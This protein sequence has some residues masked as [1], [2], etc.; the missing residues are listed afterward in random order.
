[1]GKLR[2]QERK[3]EQ[4]RREER[5]RLDD[6]EDT[7]ASTS[8]ATGPSLLELAG[9]EW[10]QA[11]GDSWASSQHWAEAADALVEA[12]PHAFREHAYAV[13]EPLQQAEEHM[14][15]ARAHELG[16]TAEQQPSVDAARV[17]Y[18]STLQVAL[19]SLR[20][21]WNQ[22]IEGTRLGAGWQLPELSRP[23]GA[24]P[25]VAQK[26]T[27]GMD[28]VATAARMR[29]RA[30]AVP[31]ERPS[32]DGLALQRPWE[33]NAAREAL[34]PVFD[35]FISF[36]G[37]EWLFLFDQAKEGG[38]PD[39]AI[40]ELTREVAG[41]AQYEAHLQDEGKLEVLDAKI[42]RL[43]QALH[44]AMKHWGTDEAA[45]TMAEIRN[46]TRPE[47]Q[48]LRVQYALRY[49]TELLGEIAGEL[50][51]ED[52]SEVVRSMTGDP[53]W[54]ALEA[55]EN[56]MDDDAC[57]PEQI[58]GVLREIPASE[59]ARFQERLQSD[60]A[61]RKLRDRILSAYHVRGTLRNKRYRDREWIE[62]WM[63]GEV[64]QAE[65]LTLELRATDRSFEDPDDGWSSTTLAGERVID[66]DLGRVI[67]ELEKSRD[68][69][70]LERAFDERHGYS[71]RTWITVSGKEEQRRL[72]LALLDQHTADSEEERQAAQ[73]QETV[74]RVKMGDGQGMRKALYDEDLESDDEMLRASALARRERVKS[75][76]AD[77]YGEEGET[78]ED[79]LRNY[80]VRRYTWE[81]DERQALYVYEHGRESLA[82]GAWLAMT[83][84][85]T[86]EDWLKELFRGRSK[87]EMERAA[88]EY[89]EEFG[90]DLH[91]D[92]DSEL[93]WDGTTDDTEFDI[94]MHARGLPETAEEIQAY[95]QEIHA[96]HRGG[97]WRQDLL[98]WAE[99][100]FFDGRSGAELDHHHQL[101]MDLFEEGGLRPGVDLERAKRLYRWQLTATESYTAAKAMVVEAIKVGAEI[102]AAAVVTVLT[103]GAASPWLIAAI[104]G[105]AYTA[106]G[107]VLGGSSASVGT[108]ATDALV[109]AASAALARLVQVKI[110]VDTAET[111]HRMR[112]LA[113]L[114][115]DAAEFGGKAYKD[116]VLRETI[117]LMVE[118]GGVGAVEAA[119]SEETWA[120]GLDSAFL[121][122]LGSALRDAGV[123]IFSEAMGGKLAP[124]QLQ[125]GVGQF[126]VQTGTTWVVQQP[127]DA[128]G[129][130]FVVHSVMRAGSTAISWA[131]QPL[132]QE[133]ARERAQRASTQASALTSE[134]RQAAMDEMKRAAE[135]AMGSREM[136]EATR[137][138][139]RA[140]VEQYDPRDLA[141]DALSGNVRSHVLPDL[142]GAPP[143]PAVPWPLRHTGEVVTWR[144]QEWLVGLNMSDYF[145]LIDPASGTMV[146]ASNEELLGD[147][148]NH[149][150][151][152][153]LPEKTVS[154]SASPMDASEANHLYR[155]SLADDATREVAVFR[156]SETRDYIVL[157]GDQTKATVDGKHRPLSAGYPQQWKEILD[158]DVGQWLLVVHFHPVHRP[159]DPTLSRVM[160]FPS[161]VGGDLEVLR[162]TGAQQGPV[163]RSWIDTV[164][165][166][167]HTRTEFGYDPTTGR[168]YVLWEE[169]QG[170]LQRREFDSIEAYEQFIQTELRAP[171]PAPS[172]G[173]SVRAI[174]VEEALVW[175]QHGA[176]KIVAYPASEV[177]GALVVGGDVQV[178]TEN[179]R[180]PGTIV[181]ID[182]APHSWDVDHPPDGPGP[183]PTYDFDTPVADQLEGTGQLADLRRNP[184]LKG[185]DLEALL[186]RTPRQLREMAR[187]GEISQET[188]RQIFKAF[189]GRDL[190]PSARGRR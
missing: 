47:I 169:Q 133:P 30:A 43:A 29:E 32:G 178:P 58:V 141:F 103:D 90:R 96:H 77:A 5:P 115:D 186:L 1:M 59:R 128:E 69:A 24:F 134:Q 82:I 8:T 20:G 119:L 83:D 110:L 123:S 60:P 71:L 149:H 31:R 111:A 188:R 44:E 75:T 151:L 129:V 38:L 127:S 139:L 175:V 160:R 28:L 34:G 13:A 125:T 49:D 185:V 15:E 108:V 124:E 63:D 97:G 70:A 183:L 56:R 50:S 57:D 166:W 153:Q 164:A 137:E 37:H 42:D 72:A 27:Q 163:M 177:R 132:P 12:D 170:V 113:V 114:A 146:R 142:P 165:P 145:T 184:N 80:L 152:D 89:R 140:W 45:M 53:V 118:E 136:S 19:A 9:R 189:E 78:S 91:D 102:I 74:A 190:G 148:R 36:Y 79:A 112:K 68:R 100:S 55:L 39:W 87:A 40:Q 180:A 116:K 51:G 52:E 26:S 73:A 156:N 99:E 138:R 162:S 150:V 3:E 120:G 21:R 41:A 62:L 16:V 17:V 11:I 117:A 104:S 161:G 61:A 25:F 109:T 33:E 93:N 121:A 176:G 122:I 105:L 65:A 84:P 54:A 171:P 106:T 48:A 130:A 86:G 98:D 7:H 66:A 181:S 81:G 64:A 4:P 182:D 167:G 144:D 92:I 22:A 172:P 14:T 187:S 131:H 67:A 18:A 135:Q 46:L 159:N 88:R 85:G 76:F 23:R 143:V 147:P 126:L 154:M 155:Q 10:A 158:T 2:R 168:C 179:G 95:A 94:K 101:L 173:G 157:Q 6:H 107:A 35:A 174:E